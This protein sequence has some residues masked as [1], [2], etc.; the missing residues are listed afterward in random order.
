MLLKTKVVTGALAGVLTLAM[1]GAVAL[2][3]FQPAE[4]LATG[5]VRVDA[6]ATAAST[7][8]GKGVEV[9]TDVLARL[10]ASGAITA[11]QQAKI[12]E[13]V[14]AAAEEKPKRAAPGQLKRIW[15]SFLRLSFAYLAIPKDE[16]NTALRSG[17]SLGQLAAETDGKSRQG[18][19]DHLVV[20]A[21]AFIDKGVA[22]GKLTEEQAAEA[23]S[24][25]TERVTAFVDHV[26]QKKPAER[27]KERV[28]QAKDRAAQAKERAKERLEK[29][30]ERLKERA[31]Q[32]KK[33]AKKSADRAEKQLEKLTER[34][35]KARDGL[36]GP[37]RNDDGE[38]EDDTED[39]SDDD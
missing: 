32:I 20:E 27:A 12:L 30:V 16:L 11:E 4:A 29:Q 31:D 15:A 10:V 5:G 1:S 37:D 6:A 3:A 18:L 17:Q 24:G 2:A 21:T 28:E 19:I 39:E 25:L 23:E 9:L 35:E 7:E 36:D 8:R 33:H 38:D 13:A 22:D 34:L 26:Y 14:Q